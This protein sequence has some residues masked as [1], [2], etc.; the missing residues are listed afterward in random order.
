M[1]QVLKILKASKRVG[2]I[3]HIS[4]DSDCMSSLTVLEYI[5]KSMGKEVSTFI[6]LTKP[7]TNYSQYNFTESITADIIPENFGYCSNCF[8]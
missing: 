3:A 4:P 7:H 2:I 8:R 1:K 5:L 6:D